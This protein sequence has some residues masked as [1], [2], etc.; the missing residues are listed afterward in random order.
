I[1]GFRVRRQLP[2]A[3]V[4]RDEVNRFLREQIRRSVKPQE[5][6]AEEVTLKKFGFVAPDFDLK[7]TTI[8]LLTEQAAAYYDF[9]RKKLFISDWA[10]RNMR[11]AALIHELAHALADQNFPIRKFLG[12]GSDDSEQS[13]ARETIVEGQAS[14]LMIEVAARR[15]GKTLAD[16]DTASAYLKPGSDD[17][18]GYPVF[19]KAPLYLKRTLI[20]PYEDGERFQQAVFAR[21]GKDAFTVVFKK[22]PANSSQVLH[23]DRY[24]DNVPSVNPTLPKSIPHTKALVA[25]TVGE[26]DHRIL[27][28][29]YVDVETAD[30]LGPRLKGG[31]YRIDEAKSDHR[32][33]LVYASDWDSDAAASYY[34]GAYQKI[35]RGKWK[36]LEVASQDA[37]RFAGRSEDGYFAVALNGTQVLS[38][39][40]FASPL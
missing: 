15:Q 5:I 14:W 28:R 32:T 27:L 17:D 29:Q 26:L 19:S 30:A 24:F 37:K 21:D 40:G 1:T 18:S 10:S 16:P 23:P 33:M 34:F 22:P 13:L 38:E 35:L 2:F 8:D 12:K 11:E 20:F 7:K 4:T 3:M 31:S 25:G 9:H 6:R 36:S 39:E